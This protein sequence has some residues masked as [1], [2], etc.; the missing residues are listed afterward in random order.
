MKVLIGPRI[1]TQNVEKRRLEILAKIKK[2]SQSL[3][4]LKRYFR[5]ITE[6]ILK[7]DLRDF[8]KMGVVKAVK[9]KGYERVYIYMK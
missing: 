6:P 2:E 5:G 8:Q 1:N 9:F 4:Q 3:T 7:H